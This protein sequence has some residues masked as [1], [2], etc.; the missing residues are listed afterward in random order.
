MQQDVRDRFEIMKFD[1]MEGTVGRLLRAA[2]HRLEEKRDR[3]GESTRATEF[4]PRI[5]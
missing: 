2:I 1:L 4:K 5:P 3:S